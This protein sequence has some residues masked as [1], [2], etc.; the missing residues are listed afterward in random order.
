[1]ELLVPTA[2]SHGNLDSGPIVSMCR[3]GHGSTLGA[4]LL[5]Y[6]RWPV[7]L[8]AVGFVS[9]GGGADIGVPHYQCP[10]MGPDL[11]VGLVAEEFVSAYTRWWAASQK[12]VS[13]VDSSWVGICSISFPVG[14]LQFHPLTLQI[15]TWSGADRPWVRLTIEAT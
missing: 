4:P 12:L 10:I 14:V 6:S 9:C 13:P 7:V 8:A 3:A 11:E 1:M 5:V 2:A 15:E